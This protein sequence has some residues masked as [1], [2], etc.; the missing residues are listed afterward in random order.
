MPTKREKLILSI[1]VFLLLTLTIIPLLLA[2]KA[3]GDTHK[4]A[5]F[6]FNPIDSNSYIAKMR[7]GFDGQWAFKL[8]YSFETGDAAYINV[9]YIFLGHLSR[10]FNFS[11]IFAFHFFRIIFS[12]IMFWMLFQFTARIFQNKNWR[13]LAFILAAVGSGMG[14]VALFFD[15]IPSDMWV[16]EIYPFLS[17]ITNPHFPAA[18]ALQL[19][20][21]M[22]RKDE[23]LTWS[24]GFKTSLATILLVIISP[25]SMVTVIAI[26]SSLF[27]LSV[28]QKSEWHN[29]LKKLI[30][31][32]L[33]SFPLLTYYLWISVKHPV[34]SQW[35]IQ[36]LTLSPPIWDFLLSLSP[37][38]LL[39]IFSIPIVCKSGKRE[40]KLILIWFVT[41]LV[42]SYLPFNLQRRFM[43][44]L[45]I[46]TALLAT[47]TLE[48]FV[49]THPKYKRVL[50]VLLFVFAVPTN[51]ILL[52]SPNIAIQS[53]SPS[54]YLTIEEHE[55]IVWIDENTATDAHV[56]AG[57]E[58]GLFIPSYSKAL[59]Y[60]G[61]PFET[62][63][64][65]Y[66]LH[67]LKDFYSG[68]LYDPETWLQQSEIEY[69][70]YGPREKTLGDFPEDLPLEE[71]FQNKD[72]KIFQVNNN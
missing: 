38:I 35:N 24:S 25:F 59:V 34:L 12:A 18:L 16:A 41:S 17:A 40:Y 57:S 10:I 29:N 36:N 27:L 70:F 14:W 32:S 68:N 47:L 55:A 44:G 54:L 31:I 39:A 23:T 61:H 46:P 26:Q 67:L 51:L 52:L 64:A 6:L 30:L 9:F 8:S 65:D 48:K 43:Q 60:Y 19:W 58:I 5:G 42:L 66:K 3:G 69:V 11:I 28:F 53:R 7:Q 72:I 63:D 33:T 71:V 2:S 20:I 45:F 1:I 13:W 49:Q 4:F 21:F 56:L 50:I 62:I 22:P 15:L 37:A